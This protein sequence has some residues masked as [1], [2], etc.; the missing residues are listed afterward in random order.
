[1][2]I[3][4]WMGAT[5]TAYLEQLDTWWDHVLAALVCETCGGAFRRHS[6]RDRAAWTDFTLRTEER[7][8]IL[9]IYCPRCWATH[10]LL[11]DFLTPR[12]RYQT[13]VGEAVA[14]R[15]EPAPPCCAQTI[16]RWTQQMKV[17]VPRAI[18]AVTRWLLT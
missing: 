14:T 13:P 12:Q 18:Q 9:R 3:L 17:N 6:T 16:T 7:I 1:M 11:P 15:E 5:V 4:T 10:T 8:P 2:S